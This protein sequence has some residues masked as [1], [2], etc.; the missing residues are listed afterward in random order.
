MG[1]APSEPAV[2]SETA[3][4]RA[5]LATYPGLW[6]TSRMAPLRTPR[7]PTPAYQQESVLI[8]RQF[9]FQESVMPYLPG[10][11]AGVLPWRSDGPTKGWEA[12]GRAINRQ[13]FQSRGQRTEVPRWGRVWVSTPSRSRRTAVCGFWWRTWAGVREELESLDIHVQGVTQQRSGRRDRDTVKDRLPTPT[14]LYRWRG[15]LRCPKCDQS[16]NSAA[17]E[18]RWSRTWLQKAHCNASA[19]SASDTC[20]VTADTRPGASRVGLPPL[21]WV[22]YPAGAASVLWLRG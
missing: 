19:A 14:S 22:L 8:R 12:D 20:S 6:V 7:C 17:C 5:C 11:V 4:R 9:S 16:P 3:N 21:R 1:S 18:C 10:L 15:S 13:R 2:S